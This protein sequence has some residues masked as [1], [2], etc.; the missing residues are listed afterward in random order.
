MTPESH[1][2]TEPADGDASPALR[3][4][5]DV[6]LVGIIN[7][8]LRRWLG[9]V[10]LMI[11]CTALALVYGAFFAGYAAHA[12]FI[13][14]TPDVTGSTLGRLAAQFGIS[15]TLLA[16]ATSGSPQL[17]A[18]LIETDQLLAE[19]ARA[20]YRVPKEDG[21]A[22][23]VSGTYIQLAG[24]SGDTPEE[25]V[26]NAV[27]KLRKHKIAVDQD[28]ESGAIT[29]T[30]RA[31]WAPLAEQVAQRIVA[32]V[33]SFNVNE[34]Q[35]EGRAE[36][37]F[38][39]GRLAHAHQDVLAAEDSMQHFLDENR[40][41]QTSPRLVFEQTR[42]QRQLDLQTSLYTS[43]AQSYE[44]ARLAEVRDT[45]VLTV[46]DAPEGT[47]RP[48][49]TVPVLVLAGLVVGGAIGIGLALTKEYLAMAREEGRR[50]V[51]ELDR[52]LWLFGFGRRRRGGRA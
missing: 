43:L 39:A 52:H 33:D 27:D 47:G 16:G 31:K 1:A 22:D 41:Y 15:P 5:D 45:P 4:E 38:L 14:T 30:V 18:D 21:G 46:V 12:T 51:A 32:L 29:V 23:S 35:S 8:L 13:S 24:I 25:R 37:E 42:L 11:V 34:L 26:Q 50:D 49:F 3:R 48:R 28:V 40:T 9:I 36:R 10:V 7:V 44:Q 2:R 17:Y 20:H 6:T 19:V